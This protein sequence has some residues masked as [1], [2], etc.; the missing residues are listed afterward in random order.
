MDL[1]Y[2]IAGSTSSHR[3]AEAGGVARC[4]LGSGLSAP[5]EKNVKE[6]K[7]Q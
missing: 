1:E 5:N 7:N 2:R 6:G 3:K 4:Y